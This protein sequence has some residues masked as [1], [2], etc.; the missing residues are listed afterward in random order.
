MRN[1]LTGH[2]RIGKHLK[3]LDYKIM[4][5]ERFRAF[6]GEQLWNYMGTNQGIEPCKICLGL[7]EYRL[8][9][10]LGPPVCMMENAGDIII[11][12]FD[13]IEVMR[14]DRKSFI[15]FIPSYAEVKI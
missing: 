3:K 6:L 2:L 1:A 5:K 12:K 11:Y 14:V 10:S 13:G 7:D 15:G 9:L 4:V 8:F